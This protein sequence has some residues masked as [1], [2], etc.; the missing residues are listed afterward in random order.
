M[1][2]THSTRNVTI[3]ALA[4]GLI[5]VILTVDDTQAAR[6]AARMNL[7]TL[8][9]RGS[10]YHQALMRMA[11]EWRNA[12]DGGVR[13]V[14]YP[15]GTQ[16]G[17]ADMVRLMRI[18]SL[19]AGLFTAVGLAD[20]ES[21]V[22]GLQNLPLMFRDLAEFE[23]VNEQLRPKLAKRMA[24]KGFVVLFWVDAGWVRFFSKRP[25]HHPVELKARKIFAWAGDIE[26]AKLMKEAGYYPVPLET[27]DILPGLATGLID[28]VPA[29]PI[30]AL[31]GQM[32]KRAPHML[33]L[34]WAPLV[35]ALVARKDAWE[36]LSHSTRVVLLASAQRAGQE[37]RAK[38][39]Q[40]SDDA[41][42]AMKKRGLTVDPVTP[43][44]L[45][46]WR[47]TIETDIHP[48][49]RGTLMPADIFDEVVTLLRDY[50]NDRKNAEE[51]H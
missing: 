50:R 7:G 26:Q 16:G 21:A 36:K 49:I 24:E 2:P 4:L 27:Q 44:T 23:Y 15:D 25:I 19:Q 42:E 30:F 11:Q 33:D 10:S 28:V 51:P 37:I 45:Q 46:A 22:S 13:L 32:D 41:V 48:R 38:S 29:P 20:I 9:P 43:E 5:L 39:R 1:R 3:R 31:A 40:E 47:S 34:N 14:I 35:G 17:E 18:G 12:P 6:R 8:A